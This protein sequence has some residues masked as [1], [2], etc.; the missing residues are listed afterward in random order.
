MNMKRILLILLSAAMLLTGAVLP[1][2]AQDTSVTAAASEG[3]LTQTGYSQTRAEAARVDLSAIPSLE[4]VSSPTAS[5]YKITNAAGLIKLSELVCAGNTFANKTVYL[6]ND[7]EMTGKTMEPIGY[8]LKGAGV[9][10]TKPFSG[11]FD[12]Q[13]YAIDG[14]VIEQTEDVRSGLGLF[15]YTKNATVRNL[16]VGENCSF[17]LKVN[18]SYNGVAAVCSYTDATTVMNVMNRATVTGMTHSAGI[19]A[20]GTATISYCTNYGT[21]NGSNCAGGISAFRTGRVSFCVNYGTVMGGAVS[22]GVVSRIVSTAVFEGLVNY[23]TVIGTTYGGGVIGRT[24]TQDANLKNCVNYGMVSGKNCDAFCNVDTSTPTAKVVLTNCRD[25]TSAGGYSSALIEKITLTCKN[26]KSYDSAPNEAAYQI[27]DAAGLMKLAALV[28][29]GKGLSGV[30]IY[31]ANDID[32]DGKV[33]LPIGYGSNAF[34]GT[35]DGQGCSIRRLTMQVD[36]TKA[37]AP[38]VAALFGLTK[39]ATIR[40]LVI[41]NSCS[42]EKKAGNGSASDVAASVV[43]VSNGKTFIINVRNDANVSNGATVGGIIGRGSSVLMYCTNAG[44]V[45][46]KKYGGGLFGYDCSDVTGSENYGSVNAEYAGGL[47]AYAAA[48]INSYVLSNNYGTIAG[49][50]YAGGLLGFVDKDCTLNG[51]VNYGAVGSAIGQ[52]A[53]CDPICNSDG[54]KT[55]AIT[56]TNCQDLS[57]I[58]YSTEL[59]D[60]ETV[61]A[62]A[63]LSLGLAKNIEDYRHDTDNAKIKYLIIDSASDMV[64]FSK[65]INKVMRGEGK[66]F[67]LAADIDL[68][69]YTFNGDNALAEAK[70]FAP[71]GWEKNQSAETSVYFGGMFDGQGHTISGLQ[72]SSDAASSNNLGLFG[73]LKGATVQNLILDDNCKIT[74]SG[75][76]NGVTVGGLAGSAKGSTVRNVWVRTAIAGE[77]ATVG[78]VCGN[79]QNTAFSGVTHSG[80]VEGKKDAGG[81]FGIASGVSL[82]NCRNTGMVRSEGATSGF[83]AN[84]K[85]NSAYFN[86]INVGNIYGSAYTGGFVG[87]LI[88]LKDGESGSI[89]TYANCY[90]YGTVRRGA[91]EDDGALMGGVLENCQA[92][93]AQ[94]TPINAFVD[95]YHVNEML[96]VT[97][98]IKSN[99]NNTFDLRLIATLDSL[100]YKEVGFRFDYA[101][102]ASGYSVSEVY[103]VGLAYASILDDGKRLL[104]DAG[105]FVSTATHFILQEIKGIPNACLADFTNGAANYTAS[106]YAKTGNGS[107]FGSRPIEEINIAERLTATIETEIG[108][109][110]RFDT[111]QKYQ[112]GNTGVTVDLQYQAWPSVTV[113]EDGTIYAFISGRQEHTDPFGHHLM[114]VSRDGGKT[115][116][117]PRMINDTCMDDRDI[118]VTYLGGGK[119]IASYFRIATASYMTETQ[120]IVSADGHIIRGNGTYTNWQKSLNEEQLNAVFAY[121]GTLNKSEQTAGSWLIRTEDYGKTWSTP[122]Q[123]PVTTPHG[124]ILLKNGSL[125]YVGRGSVE[126][127]GGDGI[128]AF[129]SADGGYNW[130]FLAQIHENDKLETFCEPH[131]VELSNGR[132]L[133]G[134]RVQ[135]TGDMELNGSKYSVKGYT[136]EGTIVYA[137]NGVTHTIENGVAIPRIFDE[138]TLTDYRVYTSYS[139]DGGETWT[140]PKMVTTK[141]GDIVYG[142]PPHLLQMDN[143]VVVMTYASREAED[144][145]EYAL[146]SYD[147]GMT[148]EEQIKLC[149]WQGGTSD[150][151]YP[152]TVYLG[153]GEMLSVYY[154]AYEQDEYCSF[155]FTKWTLKE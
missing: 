40:N 96:Q 23:G 108:I 93:Q 98:Q 116:S 24:Q 57:L 19:V 94:N 114:Y 113:D 42:F 103:K 123:A 6:A 7:I 109:I 16:I 87:A 66:T 36:G 50:N 118:G 5:A 152:A 79:A 138:K 137:L 143:G 155:L 75:A 73:Y 130:S 111:P 70:T 124:P 1:V 145:G 107:Y 117:E 27:T 149:E 119:M 78:G 151:G 82:Y 106:A 89:A 91:N 11:T 110:H 150:L 80:N 28:N 47:G 45:T 154:Q 51:C 49:S 21:I 25:M 22:G 68:N 72:L 54:D 26:L 8:V 46:A 39:Y 115:W 136:P 95:T 147:G 112:I 56:K 76:D 128:Y 44:D 102:T 58:G 2:G 74:V 64:V 125:L 100:N 62:A 29:S 132:L 141:D 133:V 139:D 99:G 35:F 90:N 30:T 60:A 120:S 69:G 3:D 17:T 31:L 61:N 34:E 65:L 105:D 148:W 104:A 101:H 41:D 86:C 43:A 83:T 10:E 127:V 67:Y 13:G 53:S 84:D 55:F 77:G 146:I 59:S 33:M 122:F 15:G 126:G 144:R 12:G 37:G 81:F 129:V 142:T 134:I 38:E 92:K 153:N 97:H 32:M 14:Y 20:R 63:L 48:T 135:P 121:W 18:N 4:G 85:N 140:T 71:I 52:D 9:N 88:G 131:V